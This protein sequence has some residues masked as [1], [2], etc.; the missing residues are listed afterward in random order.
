MK[1]ATLN[2]QGGYKINQLCRE[3]KEKLATADLLCLQEVCES[4]KIK[5]HAGQIAKSL[6]KKYTFES[7]LPVDFKIKKM[8]NAFVYHQKTLK[9]LSSQGLVLPCPNI[10]GLS[11]AVAKRLSLSCD[12]VCH[13]GLFQIKN[14]AKMIVFNLHLDSFGG[15]KIRRSQLQA[16]LK[17]LKGQPKAQLKIILGDFNTTGLRQKKFPELS[18]LKN[19]RFKELS[20]KVHWTAS[21]NHPDPN[22]RATYP[23]FKLIRPLHPFLRQKMDYIF[24]KGEIANFDC[25]VIN[26]VASD[27]QAVIVTLDI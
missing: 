1:I 16:V 13:T 17:F 24:A 15:T 25:R 9:L 21:P 11:Q 19:S 3:L 26:I 27:H 12:R 5:N 7:F 2:I 14:E 8:G 20:K 4:K 22:W 23:F 6:G 18:L 10:N